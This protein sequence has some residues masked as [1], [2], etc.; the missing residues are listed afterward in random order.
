MELTTVIES[1]INSMVE[2][3]VA[4]T[5]DNRMVDEI[6]ELRSNGFKTKELFDMQPTVFL[7]PRWDERPIEERIAFFDA[8]A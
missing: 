3:A 1:V 2:A 6:N 7:M 5:I 8:L 4:S